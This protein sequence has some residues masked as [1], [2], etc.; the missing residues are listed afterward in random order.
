M[1]AGLDLMDIGD[2]FYPC[3]IGQVHTEAHYGGTYGSKAS[4]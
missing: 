2:L 4:G 3:N 1:Y